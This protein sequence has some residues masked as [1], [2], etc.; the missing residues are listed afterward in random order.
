[1]GTKVLE[2]KSGSKQVNKKSVS[3][4]RTTEEIRSTDPVFRSILQLERNGLIQEAIAR[5]KSMLETYPWHIHAQLNIAR[6]YEKIDQ[7]DLHDTHLK[8]YYELLNL[9]YERNQKEGYN[10]EPSVTHGLKMLE[11]PTK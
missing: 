1:M 8:F 6:L 11:R 7:H 2:F 5:Y 3:A 9:P 4:I 10:G